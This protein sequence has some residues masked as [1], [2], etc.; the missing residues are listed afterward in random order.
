MNVGLCE[1]EF[2]AGVLK[3]ILRENA[4]TDLLESYNHERR[5][6]WQRLLGLKGGLKSRPTTDPWIMKRSGKILPCIPAT[7]EDLTHLANQIGLDF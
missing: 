3:K 4:S 6:E 1:A 5:H 7:G 2:L